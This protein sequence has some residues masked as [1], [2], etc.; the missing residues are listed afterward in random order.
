MP[1][2][3]NSGN[4]GAKRET[5]ASSKNRRFVN[6]FL[7]DLREE[8]VVADVHIARILR[9]M[10]NGRMEV[11][12]VDNTKKGAKGSVTQAKIPGKFSGRGKHSVWIDVGTFVAVADSGI[13]GSAEF[14]IVAVF[15][16]DQMRQISKEFSVDPR[17]LAVDVTDVKQLT[18][19]TM[20]KEEIV[21]GYEFA[22]IAED[23]EDVDIDEI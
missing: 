4:K 7:D 2:Q 1:P 19:K 6:N 12:Y 15:S 9:K 23:E 13:S 16:P 18:T 22:T 5:G 10:G 3:K 17:I 11:F 20:Q 21:N 14:E 8:G